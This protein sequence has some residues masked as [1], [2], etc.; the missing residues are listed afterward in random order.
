ME[1]I[2]QPNTPDPIAT[3]Q[4]PTPSATAKSTKVNDKKVKNLPKKLDGT[5]FGAHDYWPRYRRKVTIMTIGMQIVITLAIG[6]TLIAAKVLSDGVLLMVILVAV[7]AASAGINLILMWLVASPL[8]DLATAI[9]HVAGEPTPTPPPN[10]NAGR[11]RNDGLSV[12]LKTIYELASK[13]P[14]NTTSAVKN[15][16]N[17]SVVLK[18]LEV[19]KAGVVI[20][21]HEQKIIYANRAA[22]VRMGAGN[23]P[24][25]ELVF[26]NDQSLADWI[27]ESEKTT[28]HAT[29]TWY[30]VANHL[31]GEDDRR[32]FDVSA[33]YEK[34]STA[35][36]VIV[37]YDLT[38]SYKP[39]DDEL[40]FISFAAHELRGP[41][42]VIRGYLDVF[43]EEL[44]SQMNPEQ[45]ELLSRLVVSAN[46][47]SGYINNILNASRFDR[48]HLR[49]HLVEDTV[50]GIYDTISDDMQLRASSQNR[51]LNVAIPA[52]LP[53]IACD[54]AS[55]SEVLG[56]LIDNAIKYSNEGGLVTVGASADQQFVTVS[57]TDQGIGMP[58][59]VVSN[60]FHKFYRSHRSREN[61]A[62][63]GIGLY[64]SKAIV[65]SHGGHIGVRSTEG[66]GSTFEFSVPI[67]ATVANK[68]DAVG[69]QN[70][71]LIAHDENVI[72]NHAMYRG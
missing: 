62:G 38:D 69:N 47:L 33:S 50:A 19:T 56:N 2:V 72:G 14:S 51:L 5:P 52:D 29:K 36:T 60:L 70:N 1:E 34:G 58:G 17:S 18:G 43:G 30:R 27:A 32:I 54:R 20:L 15:M 68:L 63:T 48:R 44:D 25:L 49:V 4:A 8:H 53:T 22:P 67:Y 42:T 37:F 10:P 3:S 6:W 45:R 28:V 11:F 7:F 24:E 40:D 26:E 64:I 21:D 35:E 59:N 23:V 16:S 41:I 12:L 31:V 61:V 9:T 39:E 65:E 46:R 57:I 13:D 55:L 71:D 66:E